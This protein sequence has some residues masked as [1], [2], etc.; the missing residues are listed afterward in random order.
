MGGSGN[1]LRAQK[2]AAGGE[3]GT[4]LRCVAAQKLRL[5]AASGT[6]VADPVALDSQG[7]LGTNVRAV[8]D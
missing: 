2:N 6:E 8:D 7:E 4:V 3:Q 1:H 5:S